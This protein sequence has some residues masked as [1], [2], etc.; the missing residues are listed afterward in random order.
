[1]TH[2]DSMDIRK[3]M[4]KWVKFFCLVAI[5]FSFTTI[6]L[7]D[8]RIEKDLDDNG[9]IDQVFIYSDAGIILRVETDA[10]HDGVVEKT[11]IYEAGKLVRIERDTAGD[12]KIDTIDRF[13]NE[14]RTLQERLDPDGNLVQ[15]SLFDEN[16]QIYLMKKDT[17]RNRRFDI[18]Y[19]FINGVLVSST[20]DTND[21]ERVNIWTLFENQLPT[22]Q[23]Q[24]EDE[25]GVMDKI[26]VFDAGGDL[27]QI[28]KDP[29][30]KGKYKS[31]GFYEKG[32][33]KRQER[34]KNEDGRPDT[35][36]VFERG[37]PREQKKDTNF[38]GRFDVVTRFSNSL[39]VS[40]EKDTNFDGAPDYFAI[41][42]GNGQ[43]AKTREATREKQK[44]DRIRFYKAGN[45]Y[46]VESDNDGNGFFE[47]VS[48]IKN[49][50]IIK[51]FID[52]NQD[53]KADTEV[54]F[55]EREE[56]KQLV[57][58]S[59]FDG[60]KDIW[61]FYQDNKLSRVERDENKDGQVDL[62]VV[63]KKGIRVSLVKDGDSDGYF[64]ITQ[65]Y[66][67]PAWSMILDQ[68]INADKICDLRSFYVETV[69]RKKERDENSDGLVD[70]VEH[71]NQ[72]GMLEKI[73]E[74]SQ[75]KTLLTW[76][77]DSREIPIRGEEDKTCDGKIETWYLYENGVLKQV[78]EDTNGDGKPD[79]WEEYDDTQAIVKRE[80]DLDFD[81]VPDFTDMN[82]PTETG[83]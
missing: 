63:Y 9:Q 7:A 26:L 30:G 28:S 73:E 19:H 25:D 12:K 65:T 76:F 16:E 56:K 71:Y 21:N 18:Q 2:G 55:D 33:I 42:D 64:E 4:E 31:I 59:D 34:D 79:L 44:I 48:T 50:K 74:K 10:D 15:T 37:L 46:R 41:F 36:T 23:K 29:Y 57:S 1:M 47:T 32:E 20:R 35:I 6:A 54:T 81:G 60:K 83:S 67:D 24:D 45:L 72:A 53:G 51:N 43:L 75:G 11:Q 69:L 5:F 68:D 14:K 49:D 70:C 17:T 66:D 82:E 3:G 13:K 40:Q 61:Q 8:K 52:K 27:K 38:D 80:K 39:M 62:K 22:L 58:D 77:Y 78:R